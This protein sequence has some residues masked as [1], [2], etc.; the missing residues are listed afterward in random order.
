MRHFFKR[1]PLQNEVIAAG[2]SGGADSLALVLRLKDAGRKVIALTVDHGLRPNSRAEAEYTAAV[3]RKFGIEHHILTW[4]GEKPRTAVEAAAREARYGLLCEWCRTHGVGVLA[5]GHHRRDQAETFLLRLQ[6]GSGLYGLSC[7]L[8]VC[9]RNGIWLIRPQLN[10]DPE[11]LKQYLRGR[12]VEWVEDESN[13]CEDFQRV[14]IRK[15]LPELEQKI[16]LTEKRLAETAAVLARS[17]AY[18]EEEVGQIIENKVRCWGER[19]FS[20]SAATVQ[21]WHSEIA[22]RVLAELLRRSGGR[23]YA[24]EADE[25][26]R[27]ADDLR[28][29]G[30]RGCTLG[31]CEIFW[32]QKRFWLVPE[33]RGAEVMPRA[34]WEKCL[35]FVPQYANADLPY[36]VR[37]ALYNE[38]MK[39]SNGKEG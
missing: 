34:E 20:F 3:M 24:P 11:E 33:A 25:L 15:F 36:K 4:E 14:K 16:G 8:P 37:R 22:Y 18:F 10:D 5:V 27:L 13:Q 30:F 31:G 29:S 23:R 35:Q 32:A 9:R 39:V 21:G 6:R 2:V 12:G 28:N 1:F 19:I 38:I 17:R 26:L 7:M